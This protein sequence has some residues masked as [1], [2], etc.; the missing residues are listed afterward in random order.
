MSGPRNISGMPIREATGPHRAC[1][2]IDC[3]CVKPTGDF[4]KL[5][6]HLAGCAK[7]H[8]IVYHEQYTEDRIVLR[9]EDVQ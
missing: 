5:S 9:K 7:A 3:G 2:S 1:Y 4:S 6:R 8:R